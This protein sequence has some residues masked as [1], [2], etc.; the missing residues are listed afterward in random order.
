MPASLSPTENRRQ[1]ERR[2]RRAAILEAARSVF[3]TQGITQTTMDDV[4]AAAELSK[5][6]IY[7]YFQSKETLLAALLQEG[8]AML[9]R[10]LQAAYAADD[11]LAAVTRLRRLARAYFDFFQEHPHYY[12]LLM[13]LDRRQFQES[14]DEEVYRQTLIRSTRG[15]AYV[16]QAIEQGVADGEFYVNDAREAA[17]VIWATLH[18]VYVILGHPLRRE[19]VAADL[20]QL[21]RAAL[22][23]AIKGLTSRPDGKMAPK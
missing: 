19:M 18:G 10:R 9:V 8:L 2:E 7:L 14:V 20:E 17:S 3:F 11:P 22:E 21:Y 12:R 23:L 4:A 6:T 15:L 1:R 5:G 13:A 16:V